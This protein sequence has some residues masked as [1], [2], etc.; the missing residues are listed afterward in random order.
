MASTLEA[1]RTLH[2]YSIRITSEWA[3]FLLSARP[4]RFTYTWT[5]PESHPVRL[6]VTVP[7]RTCQLPYMRKVIRRTITM[8]HMQHS[9]CLMIYVVKIKASTCHPFDS[10]TYLLD[11]VI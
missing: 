11:T 9:F 6:S 10:L 4:Y 1:I 5:R 3:P 8:C 7:S 2:P